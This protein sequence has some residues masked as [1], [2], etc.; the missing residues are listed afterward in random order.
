MLERIQSSKT[1]VEKN[2]Y[3]TGLSFSI[4]FFSR[5]TK[6]GNS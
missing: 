1:S 2:P 3:R 6:T 5:K 4:S